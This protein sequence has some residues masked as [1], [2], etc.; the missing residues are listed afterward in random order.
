MKNR[1]WRCSAFLLGVVALLAASLFIGCGQP[2]HPP[3]PSSSSHP[4]IAASPSSFSFIAEQGGSN[5][6]SQTLEIQNSGGGT[7]DWSAT[8]DAD[9]L[10]LS[11]TSG[12]CSAGE[13]NNLAVSVDASAISAGDYS[14]TI[15]ISA[16]EATNTPQTVAV[17]L[18]ISPSLLN[19]SPNEPSNPSL[20]DGATEVST[21]VILSW[22][23][24]D[25]DVGDTVTYDV[26]FGTNS[27]PPLVSNDQSDTTYSPG[28]LSNNT[29]YYWKV[30][31]SDNHEASTDS[32]VWDFTTTEATI[33]AVSINAP[34]E[35]DADSGFTVTVN[36]SGVT[37]FDAAQY[38]VAF[39]DTVLRLD[40]V[41]AGAIDG[42]AIPVDVWNEISPGTYT[43][44]QNV[45]GLAG[46]TGSGTLAV[47]HF[48]VIGSAGD[49]SN[50][51]LSHEALNDNQGVEIPATWT[52]DSITVAEAP[53]A[54]A[55][56][57]SLNAP[58]EVA[59]DSDF[60]VT[61]DISEVTDFDAANYNIT[62]DNSVLRLDN[63][64]DG[65]IDGTTIP[66]DAWNEISPGTYPIVQNVPGLA[67]VS[68]SGTLAVLHFH[69]IGSAGDESNIGLQNRVLGD[70]LG[71]A[72]EANWV[73]DLV[74]V[75]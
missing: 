41:T 26:Y 56:K 54:G 73:G 19:N 55:V 38:D 6:S 49:S 4:T 10:S 63:V 23:G 60:T 34:G 25:P 59:P 69:V 9:W 57:V 22:T 46:V 61:V 14:A 39:D 62:F 35:V 66:V 15:T 13:T 31:A 42:T 29:Q 75:S 40:N 70:N 18:T 11:P 64:T 48:H 30:I 58:D 71:V 36:I 3:P 16:P 28:T 21:S 43:I 1:H 7:L 8:D 44:V 2:T 17:N 72:I 51:D 5:P 68:G 12:S 37:D 33:V 50:I 45:P 52:D 20:P 27:N 24:G 47:L 65:A 32:P 74:K 67:G 53:P